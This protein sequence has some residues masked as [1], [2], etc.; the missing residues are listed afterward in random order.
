MPLPG[1]QVVG[2]HAM[3]IVGYDESRRMFLVRNSWSASWAAENDGGFPGHAWMP[4]EFITSYCFAAA[5]ILSAYHST[6]YVEPEDRHSNRLNQQLSGIWKRAAAARKRSLGQKKKSL[7]RKDDKQATTSID[8]KRK[9]KKL[10]RVFE[11]FLILL[12]IAIFHEQLL[13]LVNTAFAMAKEHIPLEEINARLVR[14]IT[15]I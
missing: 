6:F 7:N 5:S 10:L 14:L 12:I 3:L 4:Y 1:E 9:K 11:V 2:Y 15:S 8:K 13:Y